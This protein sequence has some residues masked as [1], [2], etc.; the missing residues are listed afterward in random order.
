[1][2]TFIKRINE[3]LCYLCTVSHTQNDERDDYVCQLYTRVSIIMIMM[4]C[5]HSQTSSKTTTTAVNHV[6]RDLA[7]PPCDTAYSSPPDVKT[8]MQCI[9][10]FTAAYGICTVMRI[11]GKYTDER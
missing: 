10:L 6:S 1:M 8:S 4:D 3:F 2:R 7:Q 11:D 5:S 9:A